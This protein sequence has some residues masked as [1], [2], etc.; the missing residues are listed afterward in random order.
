MEKIKS[1][2]GSLR[3]W[4]L[5][6]ILFVSVGLLISVVL[7]SQYLQRSAKLK[8]GST[9]G[10][11]LTADRQDSLGTF[12]D[13]TFTLKSDQDLTVASL[14]N[15][16]T[17]FPEIDFDISEINPRQFSISP[18]TALK[19]NSLYRIKIL[20]EQKTFSWAFQ[21]K[22]DFRVVQTLP[23]DQGTYVPINTGIEITFSHDNWEDIGYKEGNFE[24][25]P[26]V[27]GRFERHKR[28]ISFIP[29]S[30]TPN[31]LYTVKINK[32]LKL[33]ETTETL[34]DD[35][36]FRFETQP[37]TNT[38]VLG[39][40]RNFYEFSP[41]ETPAFDIYTSSIGGADLSV[42]V[43]Q[44]P[45][46][47]SFISDFTTLLSI[48]NWAFNSLRS[49]R[50]PVTGL[51]KVL[52]FNTPIQKQTYSNFFLFPQNL[53]KGNYLVES[54][55]DNVVTQ[56]L[57]Q[58]TDLSS[59]L[60]VSGTKTLVWVNDL[61]SKKSVSGAKV[62]YAG[63]LQETG[64]DGVAYF[65]TPE[66]QLNGEQTMITV[67]SGENSIILPPA[68]SNN[69][70]SSTYQKAKRLSDKYW[71]YFY[72]DRPTYLPTDIIRFWGLLRDR[73]NLTQKQK[74]TLEVTRSDYTG[75]NFTPIVL[76]TKDFEASDLG[77][78]LGEIPLSG[79]APGWYG[80][81]L[82]VGESTVASSAFTV[83]TYTK[84]AYKLTL[85]PSK[86]AV[87]VGETV[88]L[89][90]QATFFEGSPVAN[91]NLKYFGAQE[92]ILKT[93][94][95][96]RYSF[97]YTSALGNSS[98]N[99]SP[100]YKYVSL[101]PSLPEEGMIQAD[102]TI[103]VFNSSYVFDTPKSESKGGT[104]RIEVDLRLVD[105]SKFVPYTSVD[106]FA[107]APGRQ[108]AGN[109]LENQW[110][111]REVGT[112]YDFINKVTS[113]RYEYDRVQ[114]KIAD[115]SLTTDSNGK[116]VYSFPV[117]EGK[118][119]NVIL[120]A[121]DDQGRVTTQDVYVS[122]SAD[123]YS[124]NDY[125]F[126]KTDKTGSNT[127]SFLIGE[128]VNLTVMRGETQMESSTTDKFL[129]LFAKRGINSYQ[130]SDE[131]TVG[132]KYSDTYIPNV[133]VQ[134]IRFTGKTYEISERINLLFNT[135][136]KKL[137]LDITQDRQSY[138]P[139]STAKISV[140]SA[141]QNGSPA[142]AEVNLSFLDEAYS[143]M[144]PVSV[145]P[146][147]RIYSSLDADIVASYQSHRY[148]LDS[149]GAEGGGC[150][151]SGTQILLSNG[152]TKN[153]EDIKVGDQIKTL[154]T[155]LSAKMVTA[156]VTGIF[157]HQVAGYLTINGHLRVT[158]EHNLYINGRFMTASEVKVGDFY[159]DT[160]GEYQKIFSI[161]DRSGIN[162]VYNLSVEKLN[163]YFADGFY[164]HNEKGRELFVDNAF[165]GS[166]RTGSDG[167]AS[168]DVKL[169][170]NL[171]SWRITSQGVTA[172]LKAGV[173]SS[174]LVVKQ[175]FFVDVVMNTEYLVGERPEIM[176][177]AYGEG[178]SVGDQVSLKAQSETLGLDKSVTVKAFESSRVDL[179]ELKEGSHKIT[180]SGISGSLTDKVIRKLD[181]V[182]SRLKAVKSISVSLAEDTKPEG[183]P[184]SPT[185]LIFSDQS[186]GRFFPPLSNMAFTWGDRL[187]QRLAR[188]LSQSIIK[189]SFDDSVNPE[190]LDLT[191]FQTPDGG[192]A[193]FPYSGADLELS[194]FVASLAKEKVDRIGLGN[195]FY[196]EFSKSKDLD[197][198]SMSLF[199]LAS[200]DE[201][202]LLLINNLSGEKDLTPL[203]RI[204]L[205]LAQAKIGD[206]EKARISYRTLISEF[207]ERQDSLTFMKVGSDKDSYLLASSLTAA[208]SSILGESEA[209]SLLA[210]TLVNSGKDILLVSPQLMAI[211]F[212]IE[213]TNP[214]PVSFSYTLN[215]KK[216]S[217]K[218]EK[219]EVFKLELTPTD[220]PGISFSD[221][222]GN[223]GLASTFTIPLDPKTALTS[224]SVQLGRSYSV[225]GAITNNFS[226]SDLVKISLPV[227]YAAIS[228]DGCYQVSD[229][230]PSGLRPI[231]SVY[232]FGLDSTNTWYPYEINGQKVSFC[233]GSGNK[234]NTINY[235][236]RV[237]SAGDFRAESALI[238]SLIAP[239]V[240]NLS[241]AGSV[242]I[243]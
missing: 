87:I 64:S 128:Q 194:A 242:S 37:S 175:P 118:S 168:I 39:F 202:V 16:I 185:T 109:L 51:N 101:M 197:T 156:K 17:F 91:M 76:F 125:I 121:T 186:L 222:V 179:G 12:Q 193:L 98:S 70:Y 85:V 110:N 235:Y 234:N 188:S 149:S 233:V 159:L 27:E 164:V 117:L 69:Y 157:K 95:L 90:G 77:T 14:K 213:N 172:D 191:A 81:A 13:S 63:K 206:T 237:I 173:N 153:I 4:Q 100:E 190:T 203:S 160:H 3:P 74:F 162:T 83:E 221:L 71:S 227:V 196:K 106:T 41:T 224:S 7:A 19:D 199:G 68:N 124:R 8:L 210:Y 238:Q 21:T 136:A 9:T 214:Q 131:A 228:Q 114:N 10:L 134:A 201:P 151:L 49:K 93:D 139:G 138:L 229:L 97:N 94:S 122:G 86:R 169:P 32:G 40:A 167:R 158:G 205:A 147:S 189:K 132:F 58:I 34:K 43:Y 152:K 103:A 15:S 62:S 230:L 6:G 171:T 35:F 55:V 112:Y 133:I 23:R 113:P 52:E 22:N 89:S 176:I 107:P 96:G 46:S 38:P 211:L 75:W 59:Y 29:K 48:P 102:T 33:K 163:T 180:I 183:S 204:Y 209:D 57:V 65:D 78:F 146:L 241:P 88:T 20:A 18:K 216:I 240:F 217:K 144:S 2:L 192:Y 79:Y 148:P 126:L 42:K 111:R 236:A 36:I 182:K 115:I 170:D 5:F 120:H 129:Y 24:I 239:S 223:V 130:I 155:P 45:S 218:L 123:Y 215:G 165:F 198:A 84:Q 231:T 177:R 105:P 99:Y 54:G 47:Q 181:V 184:N 137:S 1:F 104:G 116:A 73:D 80:I 26:P 161:E 195:Y 145:D 60:S 225:R 232:S 141:D 31:T 92:G 119:Y 11:L 178:L 108:I 25:T 166:V 143:A 53:P 135:T 30:L 200:L 44:Y 127:N 72:S 219:G 187:D 174:L 50:L 226:T 150:F 82:K 28:T 208:L 220:L 66:S 212:Q 61:G 140:F 67:S 56:A 243:K 154:Q 142:P 207:S